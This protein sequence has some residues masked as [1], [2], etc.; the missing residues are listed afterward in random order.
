[1]A[2][3]MRKVRSYRLYVLAVLLGGASYGFVSP[4]VKVAYHKGFSATEVTSGQFYYAALLLWLIVLFQTRG[5]IS[6]KTLSRVDFW[7]LLALGLLGT[8][9]AVLYYRALTVLPAWLAII[10]LFQFSWMTFVLD[11]I[12]RRRIPTGWQ[13]GGILLIVIGTVLAN[14]HSQIGHHWSALG[15]FDGLMSGATYAAF[16]YIN[17]HVQSPI[18]PFLRASLITSVSAVAVSAIYPPHVELFVAAW[19]GM[20]VYGLLIG[21]FSQAIPTSLF[22]VGVPHVGGSAAAILSSVEL[23]IAVLLAAGLLHEQVSVIGWIGVLF[24]I[25]GIAVGQRQQR[26]A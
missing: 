8:G 19:H 11:Y 22:A 1:M 20:W 17:G 4:I 7:R 3:M 5:K 13:W 2:V 10:L 25:A 18:K 6:L 26:V 9:T 15:M 12:V 24:I 16:L 23:P 14:L 21:L